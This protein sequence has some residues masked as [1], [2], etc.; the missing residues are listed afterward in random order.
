MKKAAIVLALAAAMLFTGCAGKGGKSGEYSPKESSIYVA[1]DGTLS[2][3]LVETYE[4]DNYDGESL[5]TFLEDAVSRYT[6]E[7]TGEGQSAPVTLK[8]C[9]VADGTMKAVFQYSSPEDMINFAKAQQDDSIGLTDMEI[10]SVSDGLVDGKISDKSFKD[11]KGQEAGLSQI[12]K[13]D[14]ATLITTTG[15]ATIETQ[16]KILYVSEGV[17]LLSDKNIAK[18]SGD[19]AYIIFK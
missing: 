15:T 3:G 5:K 12:A 2:S 8:D 16:G 14:K 1:S 19:R 6:E 18:V 13:E 9:S 17:E 10:Q 7:N 11:A 4:K